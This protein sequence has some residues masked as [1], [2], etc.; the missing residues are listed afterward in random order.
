[1]EKL[2]ITLVLVLA[3]CDQTTTL[4]LAPPSPVTFDKPAETYVHLW[5][6]DVHLADASASLIESYRFSV[7]SLPVSQDLSI[8]SNLHRRIDQGHGPVSAEDAGFYL[9]VY[10]D[11]NR[12]G[13]ICE[14][15]FSQDYQRAEP[16]F[17][18][19]GLPSEIEIFVKENDSTY[20]CR[21][22]LRE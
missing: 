3:A 9:S 22:A 6:Y 7:T 11:R 16:E 19:S 8:P 5:G 18:R 14:G 17:F 12:D 15:D 21:P 4:T 20:P 13:D 1:M 2:I 10:I